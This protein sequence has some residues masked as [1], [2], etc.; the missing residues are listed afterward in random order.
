[1]RLSRSIGSLLFV[2]LML[3]FSA[4]AF[5]QIGI[6]ISVGFGPPALPVYDQPLCPGD[7]YIWTPGYWAWDNDGDDY[8]WVPGTW[9]MA[10]E[11]GYP[12]DPAVVGMGRAMLSSS[13]KAIWGPQVGF[14]GGI[15]YGFGYFGQGYAGGRWQEITSI[16][17]REVNNINVT[18]IRN[19]YN[20][21]VTINN[22]NHVSYNGHGGVEARPTPRRKQRCTNVTSVRW[23]RRLQHIQ[24]ARGNRELRASENHGTSADRGHRTSRRTCAKVRFRQGPRGE[25]TILRPTA[26]APR[27]GPDARSPRSSR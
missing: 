18:N 22:E 13:T 8:Y 25:P 20:E 17:N 14:Y 4:A 11:V 10:P 6:G 16:Y 3:T 1:M 7:G 24:E 27:T 5:A 2:V 21:R 12:V 19:V 15:N 26:A 23:E 9:V